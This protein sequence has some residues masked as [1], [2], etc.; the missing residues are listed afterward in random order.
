MK[1]AISSLLLSA[2]MLASSQPLQVNAATNSVNNLLTKIEPVTCDIEVECEDG[3]LRTVYAGSWM[4]TI[5]M[6][7]NP[8]YANAGIRIPFDLNYIEPYRYEYKSDDKKYEQIYY[9][10]G[11]ACDRSTTYVTWNDAPYNSTD[12]KPAN[13]SIGTMSNKNDKDDYDVVTFYLKAKPNVNLKNIPIQDVV[14]P[15]VVDKLLTADN[16]PV[17]HEEPKKIEYESTTPPKGSYTKK[18]VTDYTYKLG[19][20]NGDNIIDVEDAQAICLMLNEDETPISVNTTFDA[21]KVYNSAIKSTNRN[22]KGLFFTVEGEKQLDLKVADV[23][24]DNVVNMYDAQVILHNYTRA[25]VSG[26]SS[27]HNNCKKCTAGKNLGKKIEKKRTIY[28]VEY[29]P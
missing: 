16:N 17:P 18:V 10:L 3:E 24:G 13:L 4:V 26:L 28:T 23:N 29:N 9:T 12:D 7:N 19:D 22:F 14:S 15:P 5:K 8:G 25:T 21:L 6:E 27:M 2:M 20:V 1:K 11:P